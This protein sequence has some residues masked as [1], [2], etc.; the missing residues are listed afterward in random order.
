MRSIAL[1]FV[2]ALAVASVIGAT[3]GAQSPS[4][5]TRDV[6]A[7]FGDGTRWL[8]VAGDYTGQR[9]SPLTQITAAN[10]A[11]LAPVWT[12][13]TGGVQGQFEATPIVIEGVLY[14]TGP[15]NHA[16]A[17]DA[18]TGKQIWHYQRTA[19]A[20]LKVCCGPVN[21]GFAVFGDRLYMTTL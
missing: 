20:G 17:I 6:Q 13:Q 14:Y 1:R 19:V 18:R 4:V 8:S 15:Q 9:H 11:Q 2:C 12:F 7:G 3:L 16:W 21:R 10:A 5:T